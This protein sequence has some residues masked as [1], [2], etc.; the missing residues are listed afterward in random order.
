MRGQVRKVEGRKIFVKGSVEDRD[1]APFAE[2]EGLWIGIEARA[3][4][5]PLAGK[6]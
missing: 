4:D 5:A 2:A 6:I 3:D 1:G